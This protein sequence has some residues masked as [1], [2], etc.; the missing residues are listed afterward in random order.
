MDEPG[1]APEQVARLDSAPPSMRKGRAIDSRNVR[2]RAARRGKRRKDE[3]GAPFDSSLV[4]RLVPEIVEDL[5]ED[6]GTR[7]GR[8]LGPVRA[9]LFRG[10]RTTLLRSEARNCGPHHLQ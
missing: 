7:M 2:A 10:Q 8:G 6:G 9:R 3:T 1:Q 4:R 5:R